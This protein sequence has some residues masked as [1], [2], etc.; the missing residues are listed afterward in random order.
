MKNANCENFTNL[1]D[2][3]GQILYSMTNDYMFRAVL[4]SNNKVLRGLIC[5]LLH[6]SETEV[7]RKKARSTGS[8]K[9]DA[10]IQQLLAE[11][12]TLKKQNKR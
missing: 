2:L 10:Q 7:T 1:Q 9:K 4:Q 5:S 8:H 6:L 3:H 11:I 12:E